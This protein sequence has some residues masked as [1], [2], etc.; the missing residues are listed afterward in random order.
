MLQLHRSVCRY[1]SVQD[2]QEP[3]RTRIREIAKTKV[4][5]GYE[6]IHIELQREGWQV[7]HKR[8]YR[9]YVEEGLSLRYKR[10]KRHVSAAHREPREPVCKLNEVWG[11]DFVSDELF[12]GRKIRFLPIIDLFSRECLALYA[13]HN[14]RSDDVV[15]ILD[16]IA[17]ARGAPT[18]LRCDNGPEFISKVLDKWAYANGITL[19]FSRRG[20]PTDNA[21]VES[22]NGRFRDECLNAHHFE[23]LEEAREKTWAWKHEYNERRVHS[24]LNYQTPSAFAAAMRVLEKQQMQEE[25]N[26]PV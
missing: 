10:P 8:V 26:F 22:F 25:P 24:A 23:S 17:I 18:K 21:F 11:M 5:Y 19:D 20:K 12:N 1:Q 4:R 3:L 6:R 9:L 2:D 7:N 14:I 15:R 16:S 13:A